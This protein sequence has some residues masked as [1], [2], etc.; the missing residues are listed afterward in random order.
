MARRPYHCV[1]ELAGWFERGP[2]RRYR[3]A[4]RTRQRLTAWLVLLGLLLSLGDYPFVDEFFPASDAAGWHAPDAHHR[5]PGG[6]RHERRHARITSCYTAFASAVATT[7]VRLETQRSQ[8]P[9]IAGDGMQPRVS[10][11]TDRI[12][13]PPALASHG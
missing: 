13:R 9:R 2:E 5:D 3:P 12:E 11:L 7:T 10:R 6:H 1:T 8:A 4:V